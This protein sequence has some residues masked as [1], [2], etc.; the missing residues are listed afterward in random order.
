MSISLKRALSAFAAVMA[1][2]AVL[3]P[4]SSALAQ[5]G[6]PSNAPSSVL[7]TGGGQAL[8]DTSDTVILLLDHQAGC[9]RR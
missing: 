5:A 2:G 1:I 3:S 8:L 7:P 6:R 9:S 4:H